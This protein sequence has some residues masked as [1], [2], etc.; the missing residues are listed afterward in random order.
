MYHP[1]ISLFILGPSIKNRGL[2]KIGRYEIFYISAG[3]QNHDLDQFPTI[4]SR[5]NYVGT[6]P[7]SGKYR[8]ELG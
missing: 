5:V 6:L 7:N 1:G 8:L 3:I 4:A 2:Q